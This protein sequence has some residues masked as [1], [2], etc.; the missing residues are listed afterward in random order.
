[1]RKIYCLGALAL[2]LATASC[3]SSNEG[4]SPSPETETVKLSVRFVYDFN[5]LG[6][7]TLA[8]NAPSAN[9]WAFGQNGDLVWSGAASA[10]DFEKAGFRFDAALPEGTYELVAWCGLDGNDAVKLTTY[11]PKSKEEL[12][13]AIKTH[14]TDGLHV[15]DQY[16]SGVYYSSVAGVN[17]KAGDVADNTL[18][19]SLIKDTNYFS[20]SL[21][22]ADGSQMDM[23]DFSISITDDN[24]FY[25]WDNS[26]VKSSDI[27]YR[28]WK[29]DN[30]EVKLSTGRLSVASSPRLSV[31]YKSDN[32]EIISIPL[33]EYLLLLKGSHDASM[34]NQEFLDREDSYSFGFFLD[35]D[36]N[37]MANAGVIINGMTFRQGAPGRCVRH[38]AGNPGL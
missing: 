23:R 6:A 8:Q 10:S 35:G 28:S 11:R 21:Q 13:L 1:M 31:R 19:M 25:A 7:N 38:G 29:A 12:S 9:I 36:N 26:I 30:K 18:T 4:P 20:V 37:W 3:G 33:I 22:Y 5:M 15:A 27:T 14:E 2:G 34:A 16:I 17:V 24:G 32:R